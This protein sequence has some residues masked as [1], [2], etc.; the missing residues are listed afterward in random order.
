MNSIRA[1]VASTGAITITNQG[2]PGQIIE[3]VRAQIVPKCCFLGGSDCY[4]LS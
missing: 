2:Y 4:G 1:S 3:K